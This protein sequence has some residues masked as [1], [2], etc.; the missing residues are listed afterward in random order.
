M[1][2]WLVERLQH[3]YLYQIDDRDFQRAL[4]HFGDSKCFI[5]IKR[6]I[7]QSFV[8]MHCDINTLE[9]VEH[10]KLVRETPARLTNLVLLFMNF[11]H[12]PQLPSCLYHGIKTRAAVIY[13][14]NIYTWPSFLFFFIP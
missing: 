10:S 13:T 6:N 2:L 3:E 1:T 8:S 9:V 14:L 4:A 5:H 7:K 12:A 11:S